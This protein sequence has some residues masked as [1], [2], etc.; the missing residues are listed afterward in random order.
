MKSQFRLAAAVLGTGV[1]GAGILMSRLAS[2]TTV[3][4]KAVS[5]AAANQDPAATAKASIDKG[6]AYLKSKQNKD[7]SWGKDDISPALTGL[8]IKDD[9]NIF[10]YSTP[11]ILAY[12]KNITG[13]KPYIDYEEFQG[14]KIGS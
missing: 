3:R 2:Q 7:Y 5:I 14:V 11:D 10:L 13:L 9:A 8:C 12:S 4:A 1:L 6:L